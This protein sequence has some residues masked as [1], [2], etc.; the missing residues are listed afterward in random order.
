MA[1]LGVIPARGGSKGIPHKNIALVGGKPLIAWRI[2]SARACSRITRVIVTTD[3][4]VIAAAARDFGAEVPFMRPAELATDTA[5]GTAPILHALE[6]VI[7]HEGY[8]PDY[9]VTLQPTSPLC[10]TQDLDAALNLAISRNA[11]AVISVSP[12]SDHP[13][14][15]KRIGEQGELID[16]APGQSVTRRQDLPPVYALNGAIYITRRDVLL[17]KKSLYGDQTLAYVMPPERSLD[18]DTPFDLRLADFLL[19]DAR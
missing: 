2:E 8:Q 10:T 4:P 18:I 3:D 1:I 17:A 13:Y 19:K 15:M 7:H 16:F 11:E 12:V 6:W 14:W 9:V 5:S